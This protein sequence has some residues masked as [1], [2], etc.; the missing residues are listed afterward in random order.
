MAL[1]HPAHEVACA[2]VPPAA[3]PDEESPIVG[4]VAL[5]R[6]ELAFH[7]LDW[8]VNEE[9]E[10]EIALWLVRRWASIE[11]PVLPA[12]FASALVGQF[13]RPDNL[14]R[15]EVEE[16][17]PLE[18]AMPYLDAR[19]ETPMDEASAAAEWLRALAPKD[20]PLA[21]HLLSGDSWI[22]ACEKENVPAGSRDFRRVRIKA[23]LGTAPEVWVG[24]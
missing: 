14:G 1:V 7:G 19:S 18:V 24:R 15:W 13:L 10:Q 17:V 16:L 8:T 21:G 6:H 3:Y 2:A 9:I 5:V 4:L 12:A 22:E 11:V 23:A 20:R